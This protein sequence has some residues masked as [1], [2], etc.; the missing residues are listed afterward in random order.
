[1]D[2]KE[3][4]RFRKDFSKIVPKMNEEEKDEIYNILIGDKEEDIKTTT[5]ETFLEL[6][7]TDEKIVKRYGS[8]I[9]EYYNLPLKNK[10][11]VCKNVYKY[12][13]KDGHLA[14]D[15]VCAL[16]V[17]EAERLEDEVDPVIT[18]I[19]ESYKLLQKNPKINTDGIR[20]E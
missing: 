19:R 3:F 11:N 13:I 1:M 20:Y 8:Q 17:Y 10:K 14:I 6:A 18:A 16:I 2:K 4:D 9:D 7:S 12:F 15:S 5:V